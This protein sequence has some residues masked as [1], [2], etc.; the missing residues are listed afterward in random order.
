MAST[1]DISI[2]ELNAIIHGLK[3]MTFSNVF[4]EE[5]LDILS[6]KIKNLPSPEKL[7]SI[8]KPEFFKAVSQEIGDIIQFVINLRPQDF[9]IDT[10]SI[11]FQ[12]EVNFFQRL[13]YVLFCNIVR[14]HVLVNFLSAAKYTFF[15]VSCYPAF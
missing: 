14:T 1:S 10:L 11:F 13:K 4:D 15:F 6:Q 2:P 3:M 5:V 7:S 9:E 12:C 8:I